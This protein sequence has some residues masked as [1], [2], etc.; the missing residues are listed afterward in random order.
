MKSGAMSA[1]LESSSLASNPWRLGGLTVKELVRRLWE[2]T[3]QDEILGRGAQL[4]YYFLLSLFPPSFFS[5]RS[6]DCFL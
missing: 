5:P 4:A 6:W 3:Q 1:S 2:E